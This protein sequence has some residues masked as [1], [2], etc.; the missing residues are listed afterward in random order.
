MS[1]ETASDELPLAAEFPPA[2]RQDWLTLVR[3]ALQERPFER[4][5]TKTYDGIAIEPL[6]ARAADARP[7]TARRG[8]WQVMARVDHPDPAAANAEALH[9]LENGATG[10]TLVFSGSIGAYGY[11]LPAPMRSAV[12]SRAC[13]S[14]R[15]RLNCKPRSRP[16]TPPT[17]WRRW[18]KA[19][20]TR[21]A[22]ST[23]ASAMTPSARTA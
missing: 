1:N 19:A 15:S 6:Y 8:S 22:R 5:T 9:E 2:T 17:M 11:G 12:R 3:A 20:A 10:L 18:C 13:S 4:L 16:G 7:I 21:P 23:S 14:M